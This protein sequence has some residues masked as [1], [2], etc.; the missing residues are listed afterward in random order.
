MTSNRRSGTSVA[1]LFI[2]L[3][4]L[5]F[6]IG[7]CRALPTGLTSP[8][9]GDSPDVDPTPSP[10]PIAKTMCE[11]ADDLRVDLDF[12]RAVELREDGL[13]AVLVAVDVALGEARTLTTLM[14]EEYG[15]YAADLVLSLEALRVTVDRL[16]RKETVGEGIAAIG[17]AIVG[18]G[19][20]M[21]SLELELR[22]P[23]P[24]AS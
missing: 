5:L 22:D 4:G 10:T 16:E 7:A 15:P 17:E 14:G 12:L 8:G 6:V 1:R 13:V 23:C 24:E 3:L 11:S 21:E 20:A 9:S 18:I 19:E 2:L